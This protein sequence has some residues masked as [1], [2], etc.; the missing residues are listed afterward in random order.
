MTQECPPGLQ[1]GEDRV[2]QAV[3]NEALEGNGDHQPLLVL[4]GLPGGG[5]E[6]GDDLVPPVEHLR[7]GDAR[8]A[9]ILGHPGAGHV[10]EFH[11]GRGA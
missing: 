8:L 2:L 9:T 11:R 6:L 1:P 7:G 4:G 3:E 5:H 10:T